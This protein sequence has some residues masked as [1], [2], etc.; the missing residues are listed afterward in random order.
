ME[1][2]VLYGR[3][4]TQDQDYKSQFS[5]LKTWSKVN[6]FK[7]VATFGEKVSGYD[8]S[9]ERAEYEKMKDYVLRNNIKN[10]GIWEISRLSRSMTRTNNEIEFFTSKGINVHFKKENLCSISDNVT[11]TLLLTILAAMA[12][13]ERS[14]IIDRNTRGK[15]AAAE[16]GK[17]VNYGVLPYGYKKDKVGRLIIN[18]EEAK[19]IKIIYELAIKGV[20]VGTIANHLNSLKIPTRHKL[21]GRKRIIY[22]NNLAKEIDVL[23]R[24][25]TV[26][27]ILHSN[28]YV[29]ESK[30]KNI[31]IKIPSI[32]SYE[33][34][35]KVQE[36]FRNNIGYSNNTKYQ[37]LFKGKLRCGSCNLVY[38]TNSR[39]GV[40][41]YYCSGRKDRGI[42]CRN[43]QILSSFVDEQ[44]WNALFHYAGFFNASKLDDE[45]KSKQVEIKTQIEF[46]ESEISKLESKHKR[47]THAY[48]NA[49]I[50]ES[51]FN[52]EKLTIKNNIITNKNKIRVL[53][54]SIKSEDV[55]AW[56]KRLLSVLITKDY[57]IKRETIENLIDKVIISQKKEIN[58]ELKYSLQ[59]L[60]KIYSLDIYAYGA[61]KPLNVMLTTRSKNVIINMNKDP[62]IID[63]DDP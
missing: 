29:G 33:D 38:F 54:S 59:K 31:Q 48:I 46:Y 13:M 51:K 21:A 20:G 6:N 12:Q 4:S 1:E 35:E 7:V 18:E 40:G 25:N 62:K 49:D 24:Q 22:E 32:I 58:Y 42:K 26:R 19:A 30:F 55:M 34:W 8:L 15:I 50:S 36:R 11:N 37:Y 45:R 17:A 53:K 61:S 14:T 9:V 3:V 63:F 10:I 56:P 44:L 28:I 39:N 52:T 60:D 16:S 2:I 47:L 43:G 5:D 41:S 27:R 57:N 23:W